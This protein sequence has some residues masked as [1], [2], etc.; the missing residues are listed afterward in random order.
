MFC[1]PVKTRR[2][3]NDND[4]TETIYTVYL[5]GDARRLYTHEETEKLLFDH[6]GKSDTLSTVIFLG[7]NV[8]PRGLPDPDHKLWNIAEQSLKAQLELVE[9]YQGKV[10]FIPGNHDWANGKREGTEYIK[11]Q[12]KYIEKYLDNKEVFIPEKGK[13]GPV[14]VDLTEDVVLIVIDSQ[15]WLQDNDKNYGDLEDEA[16][17]FIQLKDALNRN[18]NKKVILAAHHPLYSVGKYGGKFPAKLNIFPLLDFNTYIYIPLPGFLYTG[19]RKLLGGPQD[20]AHPAYKLY[21]NS[22]LEVIEQHPNLI[23]AAGHEHNLQYIHK[24]SIHHVISGAAGMATYASK[25]KKAEFAQQNYG[26]AELDFKQNGDVW[27]S[28]Y[29]LNEDYLYPGNDNINEGILAYSEKL[30]SKPIYNKAEFKKAIKEIDFSDSVV[31]AH[32]QGKSYE[33][34]PFKKVMLGKNYRDEWITPVEVPVFDFNT[35]KGGL[36]IIKRGGGKQ[37]K[38]LRLK[39]KDGHQ[40]VL[41]SLEKD[42]ST[43]IPEQIK[44]ALAVDLVRDAVSASIPYSALSVPRLADTIG[45]F[46]TNPKVVYLADDP[47]LG[48]HY[49]DLANGLYLFEER[50]AGNRDDIASFGY[51]KK[52]VGSPDMLEEV[53][54]DPKHKVDQEYFLKCRLF[55]IFINDWDRHEDQWRWAT[56]EVEDQTIYRAVPRDRDQTF[57]VNEG[58]IPWIAA[59]KYAY[60][61]NQGIDYDTRDL[62][63]L[64]F[65]ARYLDRRFLNELTYDDWLQIAETMQKQLTDELIEKAVYDMPKEIADIN[66]P[67]IIS[68]LKSRRDK[69]VEFASRHYSM[70]AKKVDIVGTNEDE[71]FIISREDRNKTK[72][73]VYTLGKKGKKK[74]VYYKRV[75]YHLET[76]EIR[77][78]GLDGKDKFKITG[79]VDNGIKVR[80]IGG[81]GKD[82][83]KDES[84]VKGGLRK[85]LIY[86]KGKKDDIKDGKESRVITSHM[87]SQ[88]DYNYYAFKYDKYMPLLD[89]GYNDDDGVFF[90]VGYFIKTHGF[91][92]V[93]FATKHKL[94]L[95]YAIATNS[96]N[97]KYK[98]V[99]TSLLFDLDFVMNFEYRSPR[100]TLNYFGLGNETNNSSDNKDYNR[101]RIGFVG[102]NPQI[103]KSFNASNSFSVGLFYHKYEV[104]NTSNRY[105]SDLGISEL[106]PYIFNTL[107]YYGFNAN[108]ITDTRD[109]IVLP[110]RGILWQAEIKSGIGVSDSAKD[111]Q[112]I[113]SFLSF[114][115][116]LNKT[117]RSVFAFRFGTSINTGEYEFFHGSTLGGRSNL[118]GY[119]ATRFT[120]DAC[121]YQNSEWRYKLFNFSNYVS[122]GQVGLLGFNDFGRVWL[123]GENSDKWHHGYGGGIWIS[124]FDMA[125][126]TATYDISE[127]E[128][129]FSVKFNFLF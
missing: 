69:L 66:G 64:C 41:R 71:Y 82:D 3:G 35:E 45:I 86:S 92:K 55:D 15:W 118:R 1:N 77:L 91:N 56:F 9:D 39:D 54:D 101:V 72:V 119:R 75:F 19:Y 14:E 32:P 27:L 90:G 23:L 51:S 52:I 78:Y 111:Y 58:I 128:N 73:I 85:T 106:S 12:R 29:T 13:P 80:I 98:G 62:G 96:Y 116:S 31:T 38:S 8:E 24:D 117:S 108:F 76:K 102:I 18:R 22:L 126:L 79:N 61:K 37:T 5:I 26:F 57:F 63:G 44:M 127:E 59:R 21:R 28:F 6:I 105:V 4:S 36:K 83:I 40:W 30:Y 74:D 107:E 95:N 25:S 113:R 20:I 10:I 16:D 89:F 122:R 100:Y 88:N 47:R 46:H 11:N 121:F 50:P 67:T 34:G 115:M 49:N 70:I 60:R 33:A 43:G 7:D 65:N 110:R 97:S 114:Y 104:E 48:K 17:F 103:S 120:G 99:V 125:V 87:P 93:P 112:Q 68:K 42:P 109:N 129:M 123:D 84:F 81:K 124:P 2:Q 94:T 53:T